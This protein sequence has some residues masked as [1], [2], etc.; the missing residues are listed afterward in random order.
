[1]KILFIS[2]RTNVLKELINYSVELDILV[3][4][5][6][7]LEN[8]CNSNN[9]SYSLFEMKDKELVIN[10]VMLCNYDILIS[11][12]CPFILPVTNKLMLNVHPTY[13]PFLKGKAPINGVIF[14]SHDF[15]GATM[16]QIDAGIDTGKIIFREKIKLTKDIDLGLLYY[17]S[18]ELEKEVFR[19]G[20]ALL[21]DNNFKIDLI[22]NVSQI[23]LGSYYD[24]KYSD[25]VI[26]FKLMNV[27]EIQKI[28]RAFGISSQGAILNENLI[29]N[30]QFITKVYES[31]VV[32]NS[33]II[34]KFKNILPGIVAL[35]YD[36]KFLIKCL[37][38]IIKVKVFS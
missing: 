28:V 4:K 38:G 7:I 17:I 33:F 30:G 31:E 22:P 5:G 35:E 2:N 27:E 25:R 34:K 37:N 23:N 10:K 9:L 14:H 13:L 8:Y 1:M 36:N 29:I 12:G 3:L 20:W 6:S 11:N 19:K 21:N 32:E 16:H 18:F 26:D 15:F 24:R